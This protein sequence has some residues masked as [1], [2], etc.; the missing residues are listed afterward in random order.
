MRRPGQGRGN[1]TIYGVAVGL[2]SEQRHRLAMIVAHTIV[3]KNVRYIEVEGE[4]L[5]YAP[6]VEERLFATEKEVLQSPFSGGENVPDGE[7]ADPPA[8]LNSDEP[9]SSP[10]SGR[11]R[12][13]TLAQ[14][15][16]SHYHRWRFCPP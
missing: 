6:G 15:R 3:R 9:P 8:D 7:N 11:A 10:T 1:P 13:Y 14:G 4:R 16:R 2:Q 12:T 5:L